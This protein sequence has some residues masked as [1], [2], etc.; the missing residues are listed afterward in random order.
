MANIVT[1]LLLLAWA[2]MLCAECV[3]S[4]DNMSV[5]VPEF[6]YKGEMVSFPG[7]WAFHLPKSHII[8]VSD[9]ELVALS[10]PDAKLDM[11]PWEK[12]I[13]LRQICERAKTQGA[14]TMILAFDHFFSQYRA[15]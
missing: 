14:R 15:G 9:E 2:I 4:E 1:R 5:Q 3:Y 8:L 11:S 12:E 10:N 7:A 13:T 6:L